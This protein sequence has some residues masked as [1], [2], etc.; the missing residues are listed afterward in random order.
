MHTNLFLHTSIVVYTQNHTT[1]MYFPSS[2]P[3][4]ILNI[5]IPNLTFESDP[6]KPKM[7]PLNKWKYAFHLSLLPP[8]TIM[9]CPYLPPNISFQINLNK[10]LYH[11][12]LL[13]LKPKEIF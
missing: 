6:K 10:W 2:S 12:P 4:H 9:T 7:F 13:F 3:K 11:N 8:K 1:I 5:Y